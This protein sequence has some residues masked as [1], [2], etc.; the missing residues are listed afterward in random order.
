MEAIFVTGEARWSKVQSPD[1]KYGHF[2]IEVLPDA[3]GVLAIQRASITALKPKDG[4]Y[5][6]RRKP[7]QMI[8]KQGMQ[9]PAGAPKVYDNQGNE[10]NVLVG[11]GSTVTVKLQ[12][13]A[14]KTHG[15]GV[16]ARLEAVLVQ[17]L[18]PYERPAD[19]APRASTEGAA[20][21]AVPVFNSQQTALAQA[22]AEATKTA[23]PKFRMMF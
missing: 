14:Y 16:S 19:E 7:D 17:K 18:V 13:F 15:G 22:Q 10:T 21:V 6:F 3:E 8:W 23:P 9:M 4:W 11:N 5:A 20:G 12:P 2:S 1:K